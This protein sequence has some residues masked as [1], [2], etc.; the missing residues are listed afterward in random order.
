MDEVVFRHSVKEGTILTIKS[1]SVKLGLTSVTYE[2]RV[3]DEQ[4]QDD[5]PIFTTRVTFVKVDESGKKSP[6]K[7]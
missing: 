1:E 3:V 2:V 5:N 6:I 4:A 7:K